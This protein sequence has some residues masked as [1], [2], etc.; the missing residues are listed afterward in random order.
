M[1]EGNQAMWRAGIDTEEYVRVQGEWKFRS[2]RS[3]PL[4]HTP[5][6]T[7]WARSRC[8]RQE[9]LCNNASQM[10]KSH[11]SAQYI[12]SGVRTGHTSLRS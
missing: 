11:R 4:F 9:P 8:G 5:F 12:P 2:K 10:T 1:A 3:A 7:G 6:A